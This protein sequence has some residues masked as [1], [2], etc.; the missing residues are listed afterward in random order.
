[1]NI[2]LVAQ[3]LGGRGSGLGVGWRSGPGS[4]KCPGG[5]KDI[6]DTADTGFS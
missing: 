5:S 6:E 1:M 3:L 4:P 2:L